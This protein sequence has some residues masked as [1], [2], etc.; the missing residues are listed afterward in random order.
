MFNEIL[1]CPIYK[2][3]LVELTICLVLSIEC[4]IITRTRRSSSS[5]ICPCFWRIGPG[6]CTIFTRFARDYPST[7]FPRRTT[8]SG[9]R[10]DRNVDTLGFV[11]NFC[12]V[13]DNDDEIAIVYIYTPFS[14]RASVTAIYVLLVP[15]IP[16]F[17][18]IILSSAPAALSYANL[19]LHAA[20]NSCGQTPD[21]SE[22]SCSNST[23]TAYSAVFAADDNN[24]NN[25][26]SS[27]KFDLS[28]SGSSSIRNRLKRKCSR[29]VSYTDDDTLYP[30][31]VTKKYKKHGRP[32]KKA[33][34]DL[35]TPVVQYNDNLQVGTAP[36]IAFRKN[37]SVVELESYIKSRWGGLL[38]FD[39]KK[40][41]RKR[42]RKTTTTTTRK[43]KRKSKAVELPLAVVEYN[44]ALRD[45][46]PELPKPII[47][48]N[49]NLGEDVVDESSNVSSTTA[50]ASEPL[51]TID[52]PDF[53]A[54]LGE[55]RAILP[56]L[57]AHLQS[58]EMLDAAGDY[59]DCLI[60]LFYYLEKRGS[61]IIPY[62]F[63]CA[64]VVDIFFQ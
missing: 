17:G 25:N 43:K 29:N 13:R 7:R 31:E 64:S 14:V 49:N 27:S 62:T 58:Y 63:L 47:D 50:T 11:N 20:R 32:R 52:R 19:R 34:A 22:E 44:E 42:K 60:V 45:K 5:P 40:N 9:T 48:Y 4:V 38:N 35:P 21:N 54:R 28:D 18:D 59:V 26:D 56:A 6:R 61:C 55:L 16:P 12:L 53:V 36:S 37:L 15:T 41:K 1:F 30:V 3:H 24:N 23:T 46:G 2:I 39:D 57:A 10:D 8:T 51:D 33:A